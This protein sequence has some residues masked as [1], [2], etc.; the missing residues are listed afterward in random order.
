MRITTQMLNESM[1]KAGITPSHGSL[2]DYINGSKSNSL[3]NELTPKSKS[4]AAAGAVNRA[5]YKKQEKAADQLRMCLEKLTAEGSGSIL[6]QAKESGDTAELCKAAETM[7]E[8]YNALL[9]SMKDTDGAADEIYEKNLKSLVS[10]NKEALEGI[11]I[12]VQG[13]GSLK[14]DQEKLKA[15]SVEAFEKL[16]G[17]TGSFGSG[18]SALVSGIESNAGANLASIASSYLP[19]GS[20]ADSFLNKYDLWG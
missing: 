4:N 8:R 16:F 11:G 9:A 7:T 1:R 2:L 13:D 12:S 17:E 14:A 10:K 3:L 6:E 5:N 18:L 15:A 20:A 19:D